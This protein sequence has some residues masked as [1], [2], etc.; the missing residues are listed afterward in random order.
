MTKL[1]LLL[2]NEIT[3]VKW[4]KFIMSNILK[5]SNISLNQS[6]QSKDDAIIAA[7]KILVNN[8]YVTKEYISSML[9][10]DKDVSV[11]IGNNLAI[12]HGMPESEQYILKSGISIIQVPNGIKFDDNIAYIIIGIAGKNNTHMDILSKIAVICMEEKNIQKLRNAKDKQE[13]LAILNCF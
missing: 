1:L 4:R 12:P 10:R 8:G 5:E 9:K 3:Y 11:Y 2:N 13:I 7:G 6:F